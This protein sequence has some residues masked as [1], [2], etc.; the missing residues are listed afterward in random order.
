MH[1]NACLVYSIQIPILRSTKVFPGTG[2][3]NKDSELC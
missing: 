1:S 2:Y 3:E